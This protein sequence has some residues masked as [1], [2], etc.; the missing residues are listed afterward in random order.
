MD[1]LEAKL[2]QLTTSG[3]KLRKS[4]FDA[5]STKN[6]IDGLSTIVNKFADLIEMIGGGGTVL[7]MLGSTALRV[8]S[9]Q[10][11]GGIVYLLN[12]LGLVKASASEL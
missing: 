4:L 9:N 7:A 8:F 6:F 5:E 1:S 2:Q 12:Q 11:G 3:D 10:I